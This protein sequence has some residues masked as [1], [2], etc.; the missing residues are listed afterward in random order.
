MAKQITVLTL[1]NEDQGY[2]EVLGV[3]SA[4]EFA[5]NA[6]QIWVNK[7]RDEDR[8]ELAWSGSNIAN[9]GDA[10]LILDTVTLDE[11]VRA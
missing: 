2:S 9:Y 10:H 3:Y 7:D 1:V 5:R 4:P 8:F 6:A 11:D